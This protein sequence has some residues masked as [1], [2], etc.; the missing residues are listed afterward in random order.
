MKN[1]LAIPD[2]QE[3]RTCLLA[4]HYDV[5]ASSLL[6]QR[7]VLC[8]TLGHAWQR[9]KS[10]NRAQTQTQEDNLKWEQ[11]MEVKLSPEAGDTTKM[12][13]TSSTF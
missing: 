11:A 7:T 12:V 13:I 4:W 1:V 3:R 5:K 10:L 9:D 8:R 6:N 2:R